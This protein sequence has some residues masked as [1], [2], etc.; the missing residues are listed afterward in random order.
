MSLATP[1][2]A[3]EVGNCDWVVPLSIVNSHCKYFKTDAA[4]YK[5]TSV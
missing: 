2:V 4:S 5:K 3:E 1:N